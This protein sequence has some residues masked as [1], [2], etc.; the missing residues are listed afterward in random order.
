M[1]APIASDLI[2]FVTASGYKGWV[3]AG[4]PNSTRPVLR[5]GSGEPKILDIELEPLP[6]AAP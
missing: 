6:P 5:L 4:D 1:V 2:V 3:Y